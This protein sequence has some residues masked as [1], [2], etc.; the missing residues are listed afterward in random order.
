M[1]KAL[2]REEGPSVKAGRDLRDL[3]AQFPLFT[4]AHKGEEG[5]EEQREHSR[6]KCKSLSINCVRTDMQRAL[7]GVCVAGA[8]AV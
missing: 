2:Q 7:K 6:V 1:H 8:L 5:V 3:L 4:N